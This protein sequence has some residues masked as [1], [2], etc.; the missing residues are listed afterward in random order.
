M[1]PQFLEDMGHMTFDGIQGDYQPI[2]NLLVGVAASDQLEDLQFA[3]GKR[4]D[5]RLLSYIPS[6]LS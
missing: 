4:F 2:G 3:F 6:R 5:E 1:H